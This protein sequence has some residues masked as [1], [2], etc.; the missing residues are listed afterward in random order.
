[1]DKQSKRAF[2]VRFTIM[3]LGVKTEDHTTEDAPFCCKTTLLIESKGWK[4]TLKFNVTIHDVLMWISSNKNVIVILEW[5]MSNPKAKCANLMLKIAWI[6]REQLPWSQATYL[7]HEICLFSISLMKQLKDLKLNI[8]F[9][10]WIFHFQ[11]FC[12]FKRKTSTYAY[13]RS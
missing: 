7:H 12:S 9:S 10:H 3:G 5:R 2:Y 11:K 4:L 13:F 8:I 6:T 1:M